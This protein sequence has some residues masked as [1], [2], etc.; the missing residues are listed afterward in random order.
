[1]RLRDEKSFLIDTFP[2]SLVFVM[3]WTFDLFDEPAVNFDIGSETFFLQ[4][5]IELMFCVAIIKVV[6]RNCHDEFT[7]HA[8]ECFMAIKMH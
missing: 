1:M 6:Y 7:I 8:I 3:D 4:S 5:H 2:D